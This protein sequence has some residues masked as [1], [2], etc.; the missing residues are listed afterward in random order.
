MK[1]ILDAEPDIV[2]STFQHNQLRYKHEEAKKDGEY[3]KADAWQD[4]ID[5]YEN[6]CPR[7]ENI[8][9]EWLSKKAN[10]LKNKTKMTG[11]EDAKHLVAAFT[12]GAKYFFTTDM[13]LYRVGGMWERDG[14]PVSGKKLTIQN[15]LERMSAG[16]IEIVNPRE[17][18]K[19]ADWSS[20]LTR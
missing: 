12:R 18:T 20:R 6:R 4:T 10:D 5:D 13:E 9:M 11:L 15:N 8:P 19:E 17:F 2:S 1:L 16:S 7:I 14:R 3:E